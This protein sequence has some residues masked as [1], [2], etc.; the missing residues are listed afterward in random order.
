MSASVYICIKIG[1]KIGRTKKAFC[2][3]ICAFYMKILIRIKICIKICMKK[4][5]FCIK[6]G[7]KIGIKIFFLTYLFW[8]S[9]NFKTF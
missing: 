4:D 5:A 2:I 7:I 6:I 8:K 1:I 3:R 9:M